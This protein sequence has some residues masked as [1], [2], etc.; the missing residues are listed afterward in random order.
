MDTELTE[1]EDLVEAILNEV[2]P[3]VKPGRVGQKSPYYV[4]EADL[5]AGVMHLYE[6]GEF[7]E[8]LAADLLKM[9]RRILSSRRFHGYPD[10]LKEEMVSSASI[11]VCRQLELKKY[12]PTRGSK[13][14][15]WATRVIMN[16]YLQT[17][18][19]EEVRQKRFDKLV[20]N[21]IIEDSFEYI[22]T[23]KTDQY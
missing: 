7:P 22:E 15:S 14:Y 16:E 4:S 12:D 13:V 23:P 17:I 11:K 19:R 3:R 21:S 18:R 20:E 8:A 10:T 1:E 5:Y 6:T 9:C 2:N